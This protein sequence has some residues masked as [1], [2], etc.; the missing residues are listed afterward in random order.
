[1]LK[2]KDTIVYNEAT[3]SWDYDNGSSIKELYGF[4]RLLAVIV[5]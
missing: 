3:D 1:M 2:R 5:I 4:N